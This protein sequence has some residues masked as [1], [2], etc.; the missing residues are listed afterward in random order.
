[1][2]GET[3]EVGALADSLEDFFNRLSEDIEGFLN[4]GLGYTMR[5]GQLLLA[6]PPFVFSES[7][8]SASLK[9]VHAG[10]VILFHAD[11]ARQIRDVPDGGRIEFKLAD[12]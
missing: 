10:E 11:L 9:P 8:V 6:Y 12:G 1:L 4:V 3:G 7:G 2:S 5:P